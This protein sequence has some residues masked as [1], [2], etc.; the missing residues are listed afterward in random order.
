MNQQQCEIFESLTYE[1]WITQNAILDYL[2]EKYGRIYKPRRL[3]ELIKECRMLYKEFV[4]DML[5]IKSNR[6]YK[7]SKDLEEIRKFTHELT[8]TGE[9]MTR[10]GRELLHIALLKEKQSAK[11][12]WAME[13]YC[14]ES[15][16]A[17]LKDDIFS[18]QQKIEISKGVT[19]GLSFQNIFIYLRSTLHPFVMSLAR[20]AL[21]D[22]MLS[23]SVS[24]ILNKCTSVEN[25]AIMFEEMKYDN[26]NL[27][28]MRDS[29]T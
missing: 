4:V 3:R 26:K 13:N 17:M 22:G 8:E 19:S 1:E 27:K 14:R 21:V 28:E 15:I 25:A 20:Q 6:G 11:T 5:I 24:H 29:E 7:L 16:E 23:E 10:E 18:Y 9:S 12:C 2:H